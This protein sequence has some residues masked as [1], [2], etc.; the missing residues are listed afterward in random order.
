MNINRI[1]SVLL[2]LLIVVNIYLGVSIYSLYRSQNYI[3]EKLLTTA[4]EK[5]TANGI[6]LQD[7]AI[8]LRKQKGY[9]YVG[10]LDN[11]NYEIVAKEL[12]GS[13][14]VENFIVPDGYSYTMENGDVFKFGNNYE[15]SYKSEKYSTDSDAITT[16]INQLISSDNTTSKNINLQAAGSQEAAAVSETVTA[17]LLKPVFVGAYQIEIATDKVLYGGKTQIDATSEA[18]ADIYYAY[19]YQ[20]IDGVRLKGFDII[21]AVIAYNGDYYIAAAEG[22]YCFYR[23]TERFDSQIY[24]QVNILFIDKYAGTY[25]GES[26]EKT[27]SSVGSVY[28]AYP[29]NETEEQRR[30]VYFVPAW[31]I[32]SGSGNS[33]VYNAYNGALYTI[34]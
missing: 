31:E 8:P 12:S 11:Y 28:T 13:N 6:M 1:L 30:E 29:G 10:E 16:Y 4:V 9:I 27:I 15:F 19:F 21:A 18:G 3:D 25:D 24:D 22:R 32:T 5:L 34:L 26:G 2:L 23:I 20:A 33:N 17:F 14:S 7:G